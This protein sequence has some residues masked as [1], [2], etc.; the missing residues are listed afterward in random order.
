[1]V[2]I[3]ETQHYAETSLCEITPCILPERALR[4][5]GG[6]LETRMTHLI[7]GDAQGLILEAVKTKWNIAKSCM[8]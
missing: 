1:K 6:R 3:K 7:L 8:P 4:N 5:I 2:T